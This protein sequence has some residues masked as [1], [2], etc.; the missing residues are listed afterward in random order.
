MK[1]QYTVVE[2]QHNAHWRDNDGTHHPII[3]ARFL[4]S[5][6]LNACAHHLTVRKIEGEIQ[7]RTDV[8]FDVVEDV[9]DDLSQEDRELLNRCIEDLDSESL[10]EDLEEMGYTLNEIADARGDERPKVEEAQ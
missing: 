6:D 9:D 7:N 2:V 5:D 1:Q 10:Y 3:S 4:T 8:E